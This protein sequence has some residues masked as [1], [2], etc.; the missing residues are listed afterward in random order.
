[1]SRLALSLTT[2]PHAWDLLIAEIRTM[3]CVK[4]V[5]KRT[6]KE[7]TDDLLD[8]L[9]GIKSSE[10]SVSGDISYGE[11]DDWDEW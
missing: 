3:T 7:G 4:L 6:S 1:M 5:S 9:I 10:K 2:A 8:I 11:I